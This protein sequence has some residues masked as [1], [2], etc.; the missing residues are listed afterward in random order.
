MSVF[1]KAD[2][3]FCANFVPVKLRKSVDGHRKQ[4]DN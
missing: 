3:F 4:A 2:I 1:Y